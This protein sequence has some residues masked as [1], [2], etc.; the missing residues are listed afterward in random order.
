MEFL[1]G[2]RGKETPMKINRIAVNCLFILLL[3]AM[4][5]AGSLR[6][7]V[8]NEVYAGEE[9]K[10][11]ITIEE[12][13]KDAASAEISFPIHDILLD[14]TDA[15]NTENCQIMIDDKAEAGDRVNADISLMPRT[16][17][18]R[19]GVTGNDSGKSYKMVLKSHREGS[20]LYHYYFD[21]PDES[22][23]VTVVFGYEAYPLAAGAS[24]VGTTTFYVDGKPVTEA[25]PGETVT[26]IS[27]T[28]DFSL[29]FE[30]MRYTFTQKSRF[31]NPV[32]DGSSVKGDTGFVYTGT[33]RMQEA[34]VTVEAE[35]RK[36]FV[37]TKDP[38]LKEVN[39]K[40]NMKSNRAAPGDIVTVSAASGKMAAL[41]VPDE[42]EVTYVDEQGVSQKIPVTRDSSSS[43][44]CTFV[45]PF[46]DV[47]VNMS[48][49][50]YAW[51]IWIDEDNCEVKADRRYALP[52][53]TVTVTTTQSDNG[54]N[55]LYMVYRVEVNGRMEEF[56]MFRKDSNTFTFTMPDGSPIVYARYGLQ[57]VDRS[58]R[59]GKVVESVNVCAPGE[60]RRF[61][62]THGNYTDL[63][64]G[65]YLVDSD[66]T[67]SKCIRVI[68]D[69]KLIL[70]GRKQLTA[71][72][73]IYIKD[74][75]TLTIYEEYRSTGFIMA[76]SGTDNFPG[77]GGFPDASGGNLVIKGGTVEARGGLNAA[78]I[79]SANYPGGMGHVRIY[80]GKVNAYGGYCGAGIGRGK[81]NCSFGTISI[82]GGDVTAEGGEYA[83]G[84]GGGQNADGNLVHIYGGDVKAHGGKYGAG[85]GG[86]QNGDGGTC[87][88]ENEAKIH[89]TGGWDGA[90]IGGGESGSGH[91]FHMLGG[92][93]NAVG[94]AQG[95]GVGGGEKGNG[96]DIR[97]SG[98]TLTASGGETTHTGGAG[99]G[100]G[101]K[102]KGGTIIIENSETIVNAEGS[103]KA[104]GIGGGAD[105][106]N[107]EVTIYGGTVTATGGAGDDGGAG[108]GGGSKSGG[109][110][111]VNIY[112][113]EVN[114]T[115]GVYGAGIGGNGLT[116]N[117][118]GGSVN[119]DALGGS[120]SGSGPGIGVTKED[121]VLNFYMKDGTVNAHAKCTVYSITMSSDYCGAGIGGSN[122]INVELHITIDGGTVTATS[123]RDGAGIGSGS[124]NSVNAGGNVTGNSEITINN[125]TVNAYGGVSGAG[126]GSGRAGNQQG[127]ITINGG[128]VTAKGGNLFSIGGGAGIGGGAEGDFGIGGNAGVIVINGGTV[129]A[130]AGYT[131]NSDKGQAIGH[132]EGEDNEGSLTLYSSAT[133]RSAD[134]TSGEGAVL[135]KASDR[136]QG[137]RKEYALI[138]PCTHPNAEFE[139][140]A[141]KHVIKNCEY[142]SAESEP[143]N[144]DANNT[145]IVCGYQN[146]FVPVSYNESTDSART[147]KTAVRSVKAEKG[148]RAVVS[149]KKLKGISGVEITYSTSKK[150]TKKTT[151]KV[152]VKITAGGKPIRRT[153]RN[154]KAGKR[155]YVR[156]RPYTYIYNPDKA[157]NE[158]IYGKYSKVKSFKARK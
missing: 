85:I 7:A 101:K 119:A 21:M 47:R 52:G 150:F 156:I 56:E 157:A 151:R 32:V 134:N 154:L 34:P 61:E 108:I 74:G 147:K 120:Q 136:I 106:D 27:A 125:G 24:V 29:D 60:Y 26:V 68:G 5:T 12:S 79:G 2:I 81:D 40:T 18:I 58:W 38:E 48:G 28:P 113:G 59:D 71:N 146:E 86:G 15:G 64:D 96:G 99:I 42:W 16:S 25:K 1:R 43:N 155:Y 142:C 116:I 140:A 13:E 73:G 143:H 17:L 100:G 129:I 105:G 144:Y 158:K 148:R 102:G 87:T 152:S 133:V 51:E 118:Y 92:T 69:V 107:G 122:A 77:I 114:A 97:I 139:A 135:C 19:L 138:E 66:W 145:C 23:T 76:V 36:P 33:F 124:A 45:M 63:T 111:T 67:C 110:G 126:I 72:D 137:C 4:F 132:G 8:H 39:I 141:D 80:G 95:A 9:G 70:T 130:S 82:Y 123:D 115:S 90:G 88:I 127:T 89:A 22:V 41:A 35:Y 109:G 83:A 3:N 103:V 57:Y 84:I 117:I 14:R 46:A 6:L 121:S 98:G 104:A 78:G 128:N 62:P 37:I 31:L 94:G 54:R 20:L 93:V 91:S 149:W 10:N 30:R 11:S 55:K 112:G 131:I 49:I 44:Q 53:E 65:W 153:I 75:A 50:K